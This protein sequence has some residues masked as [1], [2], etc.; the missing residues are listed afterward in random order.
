MHINCLDV[1]VSFIVIISLT[2]VTGSIVKA[3]TVQFKKEE[4]KQT[5]NI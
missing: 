2:G 4:I 1:G 3:I 5:R